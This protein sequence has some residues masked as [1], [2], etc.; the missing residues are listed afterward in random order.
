MCNSC[1]KTFYVHSFPFD[2]SNILVYVGFT[3]VETIILTGCCL[4]HTAIDTLFIGLAMNA[5]GCF[6]GLSH[7]FRNL[8][9]DS[10]VYENKTMRDR[11]V[12]NY[13][14]AN[15]SKCVELH[16]KYNEYV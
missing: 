14:Y 15:I 13:L 11:K 1:I 8:D 5:V 10:E 2:D 7:R 12:Q 4:A 3:I 9:N 6:Q 16:K